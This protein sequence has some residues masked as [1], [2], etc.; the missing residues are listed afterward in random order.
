MLEMASSGAKVMQIRAVEFAGRHDVP[1]RIL[2]TFQNGPGTLITRHEEDMQHTVVSGITVNRDEVK[3]MILGIPDK[4][5]IAA[6]ILG[7]LADA[8]VEIDMIVQTLAGNEKTDLSFTVHK[9]DFKLACSLL[10]EIAS[11]LS[12][13]SVKSET[14]VAKLSLIGIGMRSNASI[15]SKMFRVLGDRG[16][17]IQLIS[18]SEI[19][20]SVVIDEKYVELGARALHDAFQLGTATKEVAAIKSC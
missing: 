8:H 12:A 7:P 20:V 6:H 1:I 16:I 17:N 9:R 10:E 15:A 3:L 14:E 18:T 13:I 4:P 2:S 11:D 19:K 5:G